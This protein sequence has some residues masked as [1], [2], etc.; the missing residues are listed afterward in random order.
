MSQQDRVNRDTWGHRPTVNEFRTEGFCDDGERIAYLSLIDEVRNRPIL[1][2]GVGAGRTV[3]LF[4]SLTSDYVG[5]DFTPEMIT[6]A[7][8][9]Y[10]TADLRVG[11]ARDLSQFPDG[12]F[13]MV[14]FS[15]NG[16]D[17]VAH[18]DRSRILR[19]VKRVLHPRGIFWFSTLNHAGIGPRH[20]PWRPTWPRLDRGPTAFALGLLK[21][22]RAA[23][24]DL[25][26]YARSRHLWIEGN[27]WSVK[28]LAS[29]NYGLLVHYTT[30]ARQMAELEDA[31][32]EPNPDV[33]ESSFG[34]RVKL[35]DDLSN[36]F[37]FHIIAR[38]GSS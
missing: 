10:H 34:Q 13:F 27:E 18:E 5:I 29:H 11:D 21:V 4:R 25:L 30:L 14:A 37:W 24:T 12:R 38:K 3:P 23:P 2:L 32:F 8:E 20:R 19:E 15:F 17:A 9:R 33:L 31:G 36:V 28:P 1:D 35:T 16:I 22:L 26:N 6:A 7:Q